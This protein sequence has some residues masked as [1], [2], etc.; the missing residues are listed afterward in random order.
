MHAAVELAKKAPEGSVLLV[1]LADTGERYFSTP[2]FAN[3]NERHER[4][5][6]GDFQIHSQFSDVSRFTLSPA[7]FLQVGPH[8]NGGC[9][10][11]ARWSG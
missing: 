7:E 11:P 8:G 1:L 9:M 10:P 4:G 3:I 5:R 6:A 2:L